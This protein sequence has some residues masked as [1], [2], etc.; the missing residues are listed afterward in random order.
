MSQLDKSG[1]HKEEFPAA[2]AWQHNT[3]QPSATGYNNNKDHFYSRAAA[4]AGQLH[5]HIP[6]VTCPLRSN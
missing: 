2:A 6:M 3:D 4:G 5:T 1:W